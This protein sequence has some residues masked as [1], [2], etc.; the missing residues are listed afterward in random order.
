MANRTLHAPF[1]GAARFVARRRTHLVPPSLLEFT[2]GPRDDLPANRP[3]TSDPT[4]GPTPDPTSRPASPP[5]APPVSAP[6][7]P[8]G[9]NK[10]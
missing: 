5:A 1:P 2:R 4:P 8:C 9:R 3:H 6:V 7:G 10:G